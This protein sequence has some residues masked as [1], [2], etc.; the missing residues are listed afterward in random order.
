[1]ADIAKFFDLV[2]QWL[3]SQGY[4]AEA[5]TDVEDG[6]QLVAN[7]NAV[8][9]SACV[10]NSPVCQDETLRGL[11]ARLRKIEGWTDELAGMYLME[12]GFDVD[13]FEV[14]D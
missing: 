10:Q 13:Q 3:Y 1:M 7:L 5:A 6:H 8:R 2:D 12:S 11:L 14:S 4:H 9:E